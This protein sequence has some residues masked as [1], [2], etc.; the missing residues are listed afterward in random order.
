M[1]FSKSK[2]EFDS[3]SEVLYVNYESE[4]GHPCPTPAGIYN[5]LLGKYYND[6]YTVLDTFMGTAVIGAEVLKK[7]GNFIGY[8]IDEKIFKIAEE[9]LNIKS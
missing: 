5:F 3:T 8:E 1:V 2:V 4:P 6:G 9:K 7:G